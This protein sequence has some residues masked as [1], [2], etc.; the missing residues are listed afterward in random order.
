MLTMFDTLIVQ[1]KFFW[2]NRHV[3]YFVQISIR[4][5]VIGVISVEQQICSKLSEMG[6]VHI[7]EALNLDDRIL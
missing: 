3:N 2:V 1:V 5:V 4:V 6:D 7:V